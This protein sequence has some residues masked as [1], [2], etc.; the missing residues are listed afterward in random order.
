MKDLNRLHPTSFSPLPPSLYSF[1]S[2][3]FVF[4]F[5]CYSSPSSSSFTSSLPSWSYIEAMRELCLWAS[6]MD[7]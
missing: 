2:L 5:S 6:V 4:C 3:S 1:I 7:V